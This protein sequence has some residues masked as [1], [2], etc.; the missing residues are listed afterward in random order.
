MIDNLFCLI[1]NK[2]YLVK[3]VNAQHISI[4]LNF[5]GEQPSLYAAPRADAQVFES[6]GFV[7][8]T[9]SGGS[10]NVAHISLVPHCN[11]THTECIGHISNKVE[12]VH[13]CLQ[14]SLIASTLISVNPILAGNS[15]DEYL[16]NKEDSDLLVTRDSLEEALFSVSESF[17][18]AVII[19]TL[20]NPISKMGATYGPSLQPVFLS[21]DAM[22]YLVSRNVRHLLVDF[23]SVD[24]MYDEGKLNNHN[25]FWGLVGNAVYPEYRKTITEMI[26]VR[27]EIADGKYF[28]NLQI[29]AFKSD[30]APSRP[31]LYPIEEDL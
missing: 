18:Q 8:S 24:K 17:V 3:L 10:C 29:P 20:P 27:N 31:I 15:Q 25:Y 1:E 5:S 14:D 13:D 30:A 22:K 9:G 7:G 26:Y 19:R 6:G 16:P 28:L 11:G 21:F 23:P 12:A 4:P 2:K